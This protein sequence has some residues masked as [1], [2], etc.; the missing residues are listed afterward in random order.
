V[1]TP[2]TR[3]PNTRGVN[4]GLVYYITDTNFLPIANNS[5]L[6]DDNSSQKLSATQIQQLKHELSG[7]EVIQQLADNSA[8]FAGKTEFS[9]Q[10][11]LKKK[12][13][14]YCPRVFLLPAT[15]HTVCHAYFAKQPAK[16]LNIRCVHVCAC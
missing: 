3:N 8:T 12:K 14:K 15:A 13:E 1:F 7:K 11:W 10:K 6:V 16:I 4:V 2:Y 5:H 9:Q